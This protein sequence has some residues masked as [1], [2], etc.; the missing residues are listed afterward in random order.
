VLAAAKALTDDRSGPTFDNG[1]A[2]LPSDD[3]YRP[4]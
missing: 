3:P 1:A 4:S 2:W